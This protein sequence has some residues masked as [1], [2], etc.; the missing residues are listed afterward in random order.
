MIGDS[1]ILDRGHA[2]GGMSLRKG[3]MPVKQGNRMLVVLLL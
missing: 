1:L 3:E 2:V